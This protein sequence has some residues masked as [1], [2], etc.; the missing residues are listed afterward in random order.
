MKHCLFFNAPISYA[1][2][3]VFFSWE[4]VSCRSV[5]PLE[6]HKNSRQE[7]ACMFQR[8]SL[9]TDLC[10][11]TDKKEKAWM[12]YSWLYWKRMITWIKSLFFSG[13]NEL[14]WH[15]NIFGYNKYRLG[16]FISA[17]H[18]GRS[19]DK[20]LGGWGLLDPWNVEKTPTNVSY[21]PY[22]SKCSVQHC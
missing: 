20:F 21:T 12:R 17:V 4:T 11:L 8:K 6:N 1:H 19:F 5:Q 9:L 22:V 10:N 13:E 16:I 18:R 14:V 15:A 3:F 7:V 2:E